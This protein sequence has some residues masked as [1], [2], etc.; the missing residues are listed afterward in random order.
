M[1]FK[2]EVMHSQDDCKLTEAS[3]EVIRE[4][5]RENHAV[6]FVMG[7]YDDRLTIASVSGFFLHDMGYSYNEF[8]E[9]TR[10]SLRNLFYG[11]N[12][13]F[14]KQGRFENIRGAGEGQLLMKGDVPVFVRLYKAD[15]VD[16][17]QRP[18]WVLSSRIDWMQQNLQLVNNAIQS[19]FWYVDCDEKG[20]MQSISYSHEFRRMLGYSDVLDF[21]NVFESWVD[22]IHPS[23][24]T[25][26]LEELRGALADQNN[27]KQYNVEYRVR[28]KNGEY[29]WFRNIGDITRRLDGTA[30]RMAGIFV[31]IED[32]IEQERQ[33][34]KSEAFHRAYTES[35]ICEYY[36]N[37]QEN[38][39]ES[40]KVNDSLLKIFEKSQNWDELIQLYMEKF[41]CDEDKEAI[42]LFYNRSYIQERF[43]EG[44]NELSL[45]CKIKINGEVHWVRNIL[46]RDE[47][48]RDNGYAMVFI[49]DITSAKAEAENIQ[50]LTKKNKAMDMLIQGMV[51]L[52]DCYVLCDLEKNSYQFYSRGEDADFYSTEGTYQE[53]IEQVCSRYKTLSEKVSI[54][55]AFSISY[56]RKMLSS[57]E[58]VYKFEYCTSDE[59]HFRMISILP[60]LWK[61]NGPA[62]VLFIVQ[63]T[64]QE[65]YEEMESRKMLKDAYE[66]ANEA[67]RAKTEFLSNMSHDIR[68]PMNAIVGMTA[69]A[70]NSMEEPERVKGCLERITQSSTHLLSLINEILDMSRIENGKSS[71][72]EE[73]ICLSDII[74][75][76]VDMTEISAQIHQHDFKVELEDFP[77]KYVYGDA[78]KIQQMLF[79]ITSNAVKYT[80]DGGQIR[81]EARELSIRSVDT[82]C[83]QFI[84]EDNGIGMSEEFQ[85]V[86]FEPFTRAEEEYTSKIQGT[87]LGTAIAKS[88]ANMMN[89]SIEVESEISEGSKFT[90][91]IFLK[92]KDEG[93][94]ENHNSMNKGKW[95]DLKKCDFSGKHILLVEDNELNS[96]IAKTLI[97]M[98]K[99]QVDVAENGRVALQIL[100]E[101]PEKYYQLVFMDIQMPE[102]SGFEVARSIRNLDNEYMKQI[103]IV[104]MSANAFAEDIFKAK[105]SG[106]NDHIAKPLDLNRLIGILEKWLYI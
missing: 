21:P 79:N 29:Q 54:E 78:L 58:D 80:P 8:M 100:A 15:T 14:L 56:I 74:D 67:N 94:T 65:K 35:N 82:G 37:L 43:A 99:A 16:G 92:L 69:I 18:M 23:E 83:Y 51:K 73:E 26:V 87:G 46:I 103:P 85:R 77:H 59:K 81:F 38:S 48:A 3:Y 22:A 11:E 105:Q 28:M 106:M 25:H 86:L 42:A 33:N 53:L 20:E 24:R 27:E 49:R 44:K 88:Y 50:E 70:K 52:V 19:G 66:A 47:M 6:G 84:V 101:K 55:Q 95:T 10:G 1:M 63:D 89:G 4:A 72:T 31:N 71:L 96:E 76:V 2:E 97:E 34:Q 30:Y 40:L 5:I 102:M 41:I 13:T 12:T 68:T 64:T 61:D 104:A 75:E 60:V 9:K 90:I 98:T 45:E 7:Y 93:R 17:E 57:S 62:K 91:T 39:F 36:L 32:E